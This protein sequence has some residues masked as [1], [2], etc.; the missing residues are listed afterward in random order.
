[1]TAFGFDEPGIKR[2]IAGVRKVERMPASSG[3]RTR[4]KGDDPGGGTTSVSVNIKIV[5]ID[6]DIEGVLEADPQKILTDTDVEEVLG[7]GNAIVF[8]DPPDDDYDLNQVD[9]LNL[10]KYRRTKVSL[11]VYESA[12]AEIGT[13]QDGD[14]SEIT[15]ATEASSEDDFYAGDIITLTSG[16]GSG[17]SKTITDYDGTTKVATVESAWSTDPDNTTEYSI[18]SSKNLSLAY[19]TIDDSENNRVIV[20]YSTIDVWY[21][22]GKPF[23]VGEYQRADYPDYPENDAFPPEGLPE[24]FLNRRYRG[25]VINGVLITALCRVLPAPELPE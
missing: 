25:I 21:D 7:T 18:T 12:A 24:G 20:R 19:T 2:V 15:L 14:T 23:V 17:Q 11:K 1:M 6:A 5:L 3:L 10:W 9:D 13:A 16:T 4:K 8:Q 22:D